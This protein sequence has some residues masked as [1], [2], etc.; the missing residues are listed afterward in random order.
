[1]KNL[2]KNIWHPFTQEALYGDNIKIVKGKD[3]I[4]YDENGNE[5]IDAISSWWVNIHGHSNSY[6]A[7]KIAQQ[8][9]QLEHVIFA[10]FTHPQAI[11][12][13]ERLITSI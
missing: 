2:D 7:K 12:L 5:Y 10:G 8:A 6:I 4:L 11:T 3:T 9:R 13:A 1:M